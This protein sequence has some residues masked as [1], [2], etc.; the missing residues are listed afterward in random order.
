[1]FKILRREQIVPNMHLLEVGASFVAKKALPGQFVIVMTDEK[2]ERIPLTISDWNQERG[3]ITIVFMEVGTS[4]KKLANMKSGDYLY[5]LLGPLGMPS[6]IENFG[7]VL[8]VGGCYGIGNI[9]PM[10]RALKEKGNRVIS[11]IEGRS[12]FLIYWEDRIKKVSDELMAVTRDGTT[13]YQG[14]VPEILRKMISD[15]KKIDRVVAIGC[16]F[17]MM[18]A[19]E[20]TRES[21]IKTIVAL[22]PV[23]VDGTGM[24][25]A[26]RV[27]VGGSTRFACVD[28][29]DF[30]GHQVDWE[31]LFFRRAAYINEE[32]DSLQKYECDV[33]P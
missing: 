13:K 28:G 9:Y 4:T 7:T 19:S 18:I 32:L 27:S 24:C 3:T 33:Y 6:E 29:P 31:E 26:C 10:A 12:K 17:M 25:G 11:M 15:G 5:A 8:C 22:N 2:S 23:M 21:G 16:T 20:T 14:H 1:M 30:D